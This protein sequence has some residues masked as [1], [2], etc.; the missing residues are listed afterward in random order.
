MQQKPVPEAPQKKGMAFP[1]G[2]SRQ[3]AGRMTDVYDSEG[4]G[5]YDRL[6]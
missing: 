6:Q 1:T 4:T 5:R 3:N 2:S